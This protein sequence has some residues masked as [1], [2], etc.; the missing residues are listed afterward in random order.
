MRQI[1]LLQVGVKARLG[2]PKVGDAGVSRDARSREDDDLLGCDESP[3]WL[4]TIRQAV[5]EMSEEWAKTDL[6]R[7]E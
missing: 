1:I 6:Y 3:K 7:F 4:L 5:V 2:R